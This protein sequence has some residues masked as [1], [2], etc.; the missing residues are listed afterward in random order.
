LLAQRGFEVVASDTSARALLATKQKLQRAGLASQVVDADMTLIPFP[1]EHF[2]A[3]L[4]TSVLEHNVRSGVEKAIAEI[5][6]TLRPEGKVLASFCPRNRWISRDDPELEM[7]EDNTLKSYGP[8]E[9][10]HHLVDEKELRELF[11]E[12]TILSI[13]RQEEEWDGG[14]S[15]ELF[16][17]AQKP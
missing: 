14:S 5:F 11:A 17:S 16:I 7:I 6:R 3:V 9:M 10:L 13:D 12:F 1:D 8:E 2:D 4:A 15:A